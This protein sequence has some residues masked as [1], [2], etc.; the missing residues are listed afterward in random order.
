MKIVLITQDDPFYLAKNINYLL[1]LLEGKVE[2]VACVLFDVAPFGKKQSIFEQAKDTFD[3]FGLKFFLNY[4]VKFVMNKLDSNTK[5]AN[6]LAK[7]NIPLIKLGKKINNPE[8][9][10]IIKAYNPDLLVSIAGNQIFKKPLFSL[11]PQGCINLHTAL[12]PKYRGLMPTFWVL[13]NGEKETGVSVFFVD[14]GIDSGPI[15]VQKRVTIGNM[16]QQQL[17][18]HTKKLG[19]EA[20]AEAIFKIKDQD[21]ELIPNPVEEMTY[22]TKPTKE[23]VSAFLKAGKR[24]F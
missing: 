12:L 19:M 2:V 8:S 21:L 13:R 22:F 16:T 9:L 10:A 14:E 4:G 1:S 11:A 23:D 24:F 17:I 5:I 7:H 3:V 20:V 18:E 15:V 6:I